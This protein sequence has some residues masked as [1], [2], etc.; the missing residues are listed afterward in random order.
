[1]GRLITNNLMNMGIR[2]VCEDGFKEMGFDLNE[3]EDL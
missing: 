1:M 2:D 3:V